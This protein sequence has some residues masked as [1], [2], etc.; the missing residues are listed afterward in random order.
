MSKLTLAMV[1]KHADSLG[2]VIEED[3]VHDGQRT[4]EGYWIA[5]P[6]GDSPWP[7]DNFST[8]LYEVAGKLCVEEYERKHGE[9]KS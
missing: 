6:N 8:S 2:F 4:L 9:G 3:H 5:L 1:Q 7:D